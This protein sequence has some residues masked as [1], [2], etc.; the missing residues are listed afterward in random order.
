MAKEKKAED[1]K[2]VDPVF[3]NEEEPEI[4]FTN[5]EVKDPDAGLP[6]EVKKE[7]KASL[8][9]KMKAAEKKAAEVVD[10]SERITSAFEKVA[11]RLAP[12]PVPVPVQQAGETDLQ[13]RERLKKDLFDEEKSEGV[14]NELIDRRIGPRLAQTQELTFKQAERIMEL[15]PST[16]P[17]FKKYRGEIDKYIAANF[18]GFERDPR[19]LELAFRQVQFSYVDDIAQERANVILEQERKK[20]SSE[21]R[22]PVL[23]EGASSAGA[24][25]VQPRRK[26]VVQI[27]Q[28]DREE[29]DRMGVE[30]SVIAARRSRSVS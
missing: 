18:K 28:A 26:I 16:G 24:G 20:P 11:E 10:P 30:P 19:A 27:T 14:I 1:L 17:V 4:E 13:F 5:E 15:D 6:E 9:E 22:E 8:Y 12:A 25:A 3:E 23:M 29:A 7:S 21:K 2:D